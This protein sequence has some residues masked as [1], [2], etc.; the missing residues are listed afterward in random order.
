MI[1]AQG[2]FNATSTLIFNPAAARADLYLYEG[3]KELGAVSKSL[4]FAPDPTTP[5]LPPDTIIGVD[6]LLAAL[7]NNGGPTRTQALLPGSIAIDAGSN[8]Q[9][10][11]F[12]QR[13]S[14]FPR[15]LGTATDIGAFEA[16]AATI[17]PGAGS[18]VPAP[19]LSAYGLPALVLALLGVGARRYV[20][21][22]S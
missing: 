6:P 1:Y 14:G 10:L 11:P 2:V 5:P 3:A 9:E 22:R 15:T 17:P 8:P 7:T 13:D 21:G 18:T 20:R 19:T 4:I 12:D 16:A